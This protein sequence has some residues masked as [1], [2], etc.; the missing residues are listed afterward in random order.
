MEL[1]LAQ[2]EESS[3]TETATSPTSSFAVKD[4]A[5]VPWMAGVDSA[6]NLRELR[7]RLKACPVESVF[8]HFCE[9]HIRA[10]FDD[11]EFRNDFAVW[12]RHTLRE[13]VLAE[14]LGV[15]NPYLFADMETLRRHVIDL[16]DER[17]A[18]LPM[19]PWAPRDQG[20][21]FVRGVTVVFDTELR[22]DTLRELS[23]GMGTLSLGSI[24]YHFVGARRRPPKGEDDFTAWLRQLDPVPE[25]LISRLGKIDFY[26]LRLQEIRQ[27]LIEQFSKGFAS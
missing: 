11:P 13:R 10:S 25:D 24:Y 15:I 9:T 4:C 21:Q 14:R 12:I 2:W 8:H 27:R 6:L 3:V 1:R 18:E 22:F 17:L 5:V 23:K 16:I 19:I 20:F 26:F 7:E